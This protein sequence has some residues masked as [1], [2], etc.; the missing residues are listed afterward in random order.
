MKTIARIYPHPPL[1]ES[2]ENTIARFIQSENNN[3][4]YL[5]INALISLVNVSPKSAVQHQMT[6]VECLESKDETLK[7][8]ILELLYKMANPSNLDIITDKLMQQLQLSTDEHFRKDIVN[9]I[10]SVFPSHPIHYA[11]KVGNN[12]GLLSQFCKGTPPPESR[13]SSS[14]HCHPITYLLLH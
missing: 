12:W 11:L 3:L 9:K 14:F 4:K 10:Y 6:V 5:G 7:R 8:E 2:A 1:I 13:R